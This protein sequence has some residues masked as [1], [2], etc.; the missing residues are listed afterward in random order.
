MYK[1]QGDTGKMAYY[2]EKEIWSSVFVVPCGVVDKHLKLCGDTALKVLLILLRRGGAA[3]IGELCRLTGRAEQEVQDALAYWTGAGVLAGERAEEHPVYTAESAVR[4]AEPEPLLS[5]TEQ[6]DEAPDEAGD[7]QAR[8]VRSLTHSRPRL[9]TQEIGEMAQADEGI[10][11]LLQE[12]QNVLGKPLTPVASDTVASLYSYY[13]MK[14]DLV[15]MLLQYCVTIG[16]DSMRYVEKVA[17]TW[18]EKG[19]DS[20]E[21]AEEEILRVTQLSGVEQKVKSAFGIYDRKLVPSEKKYVA[22]WTVEYG[23]SLDMITLA[24]ERAVDQKGKL[25]FP[26][27]GGILSNWHAKGIKTPAQALREMQEKRSAAPS[28]AGD[29]S[30]ASY[31]LGEL[32]RIIASKGIF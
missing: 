13:G 27:I 15:L 25:S 32:E 18:L 16:K 9:T 6:P 7:A 1:M 21:K 3:E 23:F 5:Y 28:P 12:S 26:Y 4:A 2:L 17:A 30:G 24:F 19:I 11:F 8:K 31:D 10:V 22:V 14:P 20:H 29:G